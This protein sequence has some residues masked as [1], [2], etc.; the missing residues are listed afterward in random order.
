[1]RRV[2]VQE[3][4]LTLPSPA[5]WGEE[6]SPKESRSRPPLAPP[7]R[8][9]EAGAAIKSTLAE[10]AKPAAVIAHLKSF[11]RVDPVPY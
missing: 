4:P 2:T 11:I 3:R 10:K 1:M 8:K 5:G 6:K 7:L 9:G